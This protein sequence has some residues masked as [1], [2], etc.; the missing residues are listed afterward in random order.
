MRSRTG[1]DASSSSPTTRYASGGLSRG[2]PVSATRFAAVKKRAA[3]RVPPSPRSRASRATQA[4][5]GQGFPK[6]SRRGRPRPQLGWPRPGPAPILIGDDGRLGAHWFRHDTAET[7]GADVELEAKMRQTT[8]SGA[9]GGQENCFALLTG[10]DQ[11]LT[12]RR[13]RGKSQDLTPNAPKIRVKR[14]CARGSGPCD[15]LYGGRE[16]G[17]ASPSALPSW[18]RAES[19]A[20]LRRTRLSKGFAPWAVKGTARW[21][22]PDHRLDP[23]G[24]L[25]TDR[26]RHQM[27]ESQD[28]DVEPEANLQPT[29]I[30]R[31]LRCE[32]IRSDY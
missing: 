13:S 19:G 27:T 7:Q 17:R 1:L 32:R 24:R 8:T 4:C 5:I 25:G 29:T 21:P 26:F 20:S 18:S 3:R 31:A 14:F 6:D 28:P 30:G 22:Q 16:A 11:S 9:Y 15:T 12:P 10:A 23:D 2:A